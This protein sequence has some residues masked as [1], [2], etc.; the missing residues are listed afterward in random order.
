MDLLLETAIKAALKAG[1][2][3]LKIYND[4]ASD[5]E[6]EHKA[7]QSPLTLSLIHI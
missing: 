5:F 3:I 4:P 6:I 2:E 1:E 7:D